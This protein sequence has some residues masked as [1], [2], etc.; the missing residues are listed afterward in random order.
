MDPNNTE[1][2]P[3]K[4]FPADMKAPEKNEIVSELS[5]YGYTESKG[6]AIAGGNDLALPFF[7]DNDQA[8]DAFCECWE[9]GMITEER[10][11]EAVKRVLAAQSKTLREPKFTEVTEDNYTAKVNVPFVLLSFSAV[12][13]RVFL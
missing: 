6:L 2:I 13:S 3:G 12:F 1:L 5:K 8:F 9:Q 10:L 4:H 11:D 7:R